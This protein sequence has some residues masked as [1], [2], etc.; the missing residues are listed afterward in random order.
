VEFVLQGEGVEVVLDGGTDIKAG[1]TYSKF[2]DVPDAPISSFETTLPEGPHSILSAT[3]NLCAQSL[4][5]PTT[6]VGQ[7]GAQVTQRTNVAVT[8]CRPVTIIMR[9]LSG[10]SV[11]LA[12]RLT[13]K[14]V[15]TITGKGLKRYRKT[16]AAGSHQIEIGL[17]KAGLAARKH[18]GTTK[19]TV[20]LRRGA[21]TS[22]AATALK[23]EN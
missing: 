4:V 17:S 13:A 11:V 18:R 7:N 9:K 12:F 16:L 1:V 3:G 21:T 20:A 10:R 15:V 14:G 19:I 5:M 2:E 8:G 6:I 23:L 22:S